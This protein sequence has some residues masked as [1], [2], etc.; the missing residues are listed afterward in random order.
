MTQSGHRPPPNL[1]HRPK[2]VPTSSST[3]LAASP[4]ST[5]PQ[6]SRPSSRSRQTSPIR[7]GSSTDASDK[8]TAAL[9][10]RVLCPHSHGEPRP[11]NELLPPLTS[12]NDVDLQLYALI[13]IVIKDTVQSW[14][15]KITPDQSFV[16]EVV[17]IVAHCTTQLESR[18]RSIDLESLIFDEIPYLIENH[19]NGKY[20]FIGISVRM[21]CQ[22][23]HVTAYRISH[24]PRLETRISAD[25]RAIYHSLQP[26]PA[27]T[28][29]PDP[30]IPATATEQQD[31]ESDYRQ[32]LVQGALAV[33]LPTED[34]E[35][36]CLRTLVADVIAETILG[37]SIGGRVCEGWFLWVSITKLIEVV[38]AKMAPKAR[39]EQ[40]EV[41]TRSRL[42]KYGLL[43]NHSD[44]KEP[45]KQQ[46]GRSTFSSVFWRVLQ[47][48]YLMFLTLRFVILGFS[49]SRSLP[50]RSS[51]TSRSRSTGEKGRMEGRQ[52][53]SGKPRPILSFRLLPLCS[54]LLD[55]PRRKVWLSGSFALMRHQ[56]IH[57]PLRVGA[58]DGIIDQ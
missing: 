3:S 54:S 32:L 50:L 41:D 47:Y 19:I 49:A 33:L 44:V 42:E 17:R 51:T 4:I 56:L 24:S 9:I 7:S 55:L 35:N 15:G 29:I 1:Q 23:T 48:G 34:L 58:T 16:E 8:A 13:A 22:L 36:A 45:S 18:L 21:L 39:G 10:R 11:I 14:Y 5:T 30:A 40:I 57:G 27:L 25:P 2:A 28:P 20:T 26:H 12:S 52:D 6:L 37:S 43:A 46:K 38:K 53:Q 31:R